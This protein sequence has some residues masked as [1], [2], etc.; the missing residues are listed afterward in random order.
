[1]EAQNF[2]TPSV[3][4]K[5]TENSTEAAKNNVLE[6][7][8]ISKVRASLR[9]CLHALSSLSFYVYLHMY[10]YICLLINVFEECVS[11]YVYRFTVLFVCIYVCV[12]IYTCYMMIA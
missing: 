12:H 4:A 2:R 1:M 9:A 6:A 5:G 3:R 11:V 8:E 7:R 10:S